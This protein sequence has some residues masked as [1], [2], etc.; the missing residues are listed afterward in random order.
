MLPG[1]PG[2]MND[3]VRVLSVQAVKLRQIGLKSVFPRAFDDA[4]PCF[5]AADPVSLHLFP[6]PL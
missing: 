1:M 2:E 6:W 3:R 5:F 4:R